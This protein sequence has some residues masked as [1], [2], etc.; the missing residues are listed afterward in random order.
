MPDAK[1]PKRIRDPVHGLIVF[2]SEG[3]DQLAWALL[4]TPEMQRLRR[5]KQLGTSE[6]V[7]PGATHSRFAHSV[8]VFH[9]ARVL[10][11]I[12]RRELEDAVN[13]SREQVAILAAL[14]HDIGHGPLSHT[15]EDVQ[16]GR[17]QKKRIPPPSTALSSG[18]LRGSLGAEP[19]QRGMWMCPQMRSWT[20]MASGGPTSGGR[21]H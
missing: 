3:L 10:V 16:K 11:Q 8:G 5:V 20:Q 2:T 9:T 14:L 21:R 15:F 13:E 18:R 4:N 17:G 7:F 6:F 1:Q 19:R 12:I